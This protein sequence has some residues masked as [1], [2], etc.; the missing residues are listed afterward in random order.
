MTS[1]STGYRHSAYIQSLAE[2]GAPRALLR[3]GGYLLERAISGFPYRDAMGCYPLFSCTDWRGLRADID[4]LARDLVCVSLVTDPFASVSS[5]ELLD[6]F[7]YRVV[8]FKSHFV[9]DMR[10]SPDKFVTQH[11]RHYAR[12]ARSLVDVERCEDPGRFLE[13]WLVLYSNLIERHRLKGIKAFSRRAFAEQL[14]T[15]G[16]VMLRA[17]HE[18]RAVGAH[19]WYA[20]GDVLHSHL[21]ACSPRGYELMA[22]YALHSFALETFAGEARWINFGAGAGL[23]SRGT[24]GLTKF[25][26]GWA[27]ETRTAYFCARILDSRIYSELLVAAG[28]PD[29][30]YFPGYRKGEFV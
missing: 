14:N 24:D 5:D 2:F 7:K 3:S 29:E 13:E 19:L 26:R 21:T 15:P 4:E 18:G 25:K 10:R 16:M 1:S 9:A 30:N 27:T 6:C 28:Q 8:P 17:I 20:H 11:H 23:D 22:S 12:K